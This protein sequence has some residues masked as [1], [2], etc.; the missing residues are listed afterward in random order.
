LVG[1]VETTKNILQDLREDRRNIRSN[2]SDL[3][4][5]VNLIEHF[6]RRPIPPS[7]DSFLQPGVVSLTA[8]V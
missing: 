2:L 4:K 5:L 8:E 6:C 7:F 3:G 1:F